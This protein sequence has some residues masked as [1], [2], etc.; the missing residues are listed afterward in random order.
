MKLIYLFFL[1]SLL[2]SI[3]YA[4]ESQNAA[5]LIQ[6]QIKHNVIVSGP[7]RGLKTNALISKFENDEVIVYS[8]Q[9]NYETLY[10]S[11]QKNN[12]YSSYGFAA[13]SEN[14]EQAQEVFSIMEHLFNQQKE[15]PIDE[16][17]GR[18]SYSIDLSCVV[19]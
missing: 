13:D 16:P 18:P 5:K 3:V 6:Y 10:S 14:S 2:L 15:K 7:A 11:R 9:D 1:Q 8:S 17:K 19:Q 12:M 4:A